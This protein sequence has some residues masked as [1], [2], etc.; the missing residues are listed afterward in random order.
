MNFNFFNLLPAS[1]KTAFFCLFFSQLAVSQTFVGIEKKIE[2]KI[3]DQQFT[4]YEVYEMDLN[5]LV[6]SCKIQETS[7]K[8]LLQ[9]GT[10]HWDLELNSSEIFAKD[11]I[12]QTILPSGERVIST[13]IPNI[14]FKGNEKNSNAKARFV[15]DEGYLSGLIIEE[16]DEYYIEQ[17]NRFVKNSPDNQFVIYA[18][19]AVKR[20]EKDGCIALE[21]ANFQ[22]KNENSIV[23]NSES[24]KSVFACFQLQVAV[25]SDRTMFTKYGSVASVQAH[26]VTVL[27]NVQTNY[28]GQFN[29]DLQFII[30]TNLVFQG[31]DPFTTNTDAGTLLDN[32]TTWGQGGGF[33]SVQFDLGELWTNRD[34]NG[35]TIG[36][37][38]VDAL[39]DP[40]KYH[41]LQDFTTNSDNLRCMTSHEIGHNLN[42]NHD[43]T[44]PPNTI[45]CPF[46]STSNSWSNGSKNTI[47]AYLPPFIAN[48]CLSPCGGSSTNPT[49][50]FSF[51]PNQVCVG[52]NVNFADQ[53]TGGTVT[54]RS[55][56]FQSGSPSSST[57]ANPTANWS[58]PGTYNVTLTVNGGSTNQQQVTVIGPANPSFT[59]IADGLTVTFTNTST[60]ASG[61]VYTWN[62]G[63]GSTSTQTNPTHIYSTSGT[64]LVTLQITTNCGTSSVNNNVTTGPVVNFVANVTNICAGGQVQFTQLC[65]P[66]VQSFNWVFQSGSPNSSNLANPII[67]YNQV[68][69]FYVQLQANSPSGQTVV[70]K[71][72]YI[73]V[74]P[75][76]V[77]NFTFSTTGFN[78]FFTNTSQNGTTYLWNFGDGSTST[79][80]SP[81]HNYTS[82]GT[83]QVTLSVTG[84]CGTV[85]TSKT[86]IL[87]SAPATAFTAST[88]NGCAPLIVQYTN[89]TSGLNNT[90]NWTFPG[91]TPST[92]N[93]AN[94]SIV[95]QNSGVFNA[96]LLATNNVGSNTVTQNNLINVTSVP[97]ATFTSSTNL[98]AVTFTNTSIGATAYQ[99]NFGNGQTSTQTSP[100]NTF[101]SS[102][103][104]TVVL[105]STNACGNATSTQNVVVLLPPIANFIQTPNPSTGCAPMTIQYNSNST[106]TVSGYNWTFPG[107]T[108]ATSTQA[109]PSVQYLAAGMYNVSLTVSNA[110]G[111]NSIAQT[112]VVNVGAAPN[113]IF[114]SANNGLVAT[115]TN[116]SI[117]ATAYEWT[118]GDGISSTLANPQHTYVTD[119]TY[120]VTLTAE[121]T[122]GEK[123][124]TQTV[125]IQTAPTPNFTAL[126]TVGC[127]P[128]SVQ[129]TN[130][131]STNALQ[132][133]WSFPG[134]NPAFSTLPNPTVVYQ[135]AGNYT[136]SLTATNSA[137][138]NLVSKNNFISAGFG[139]AADFTATNAGF[140]AT[141][142]NTSLGATSYF[143]NFGDG[144]TSSNQNPQ[145][146][147]SLDGAYTVTM[148]AYNSCGENTKTSTVTIQ[149][150]P[151]ANFSAA[152]TSGCSPMIVQFSNL[153][154]ANTVQYNWSFPGGTPAT[155]TAS[156][157]SVVYNSVGLYSISL[158]VSN[159]AGEHTMVKTDFISVGT[160]PQ[161][162]FTS[163]MAG[164]LATF[165]NTSTN[166]TSY[167]WTFGDGTNNTLQYPTHTYSND[168]NYTVTLAA[169]NAC[170]TINN[171][172][173]V[174]VVTPPTAGFTTNQ[175]VGCAPFSVQ[176]SNTSSSNTTQYNWTFVGGIPATS[177]EANPLVVYPNVGTYSAILTVSNAAGI[178]T[179]T[180]NNILQVNGLPT[181]D[182]D[183]S[184]NLA[185]L[186]LI[187]N[188]TNA[189][190]YL[191]NFGDGTTSTIQ[192]SGHNYTSDGTY[193]VS[194]TSTN[195]CGSVTS[196]KSVTITTPPLANFSVIQSTGCAPM[197]VQFSDASSANTTGWLWEFTGATIAASTE[198]NPIVT[199]P[200]A[201]TFDVKLTVSNA[202]GN[203]E[204]VKSNF[205][206]INTVPEVLFTTQNDVNGL[207]TFTNASQNANSY[208]WSFGDGTTSTQATPSHLYTNDGIYIISLTAVNACGQSTN[209]Q[210]VTVI[211]PPTAGFTIPSVNSCVPVSMT[212]DNTSSSNASTYSWSFEGGNPAISSEKNP[213]INWTTSGVYTIKL[214]VT[215]AA[216]SSELVQGI[217]VKGPPAASFNTTT[218]GLSVI[219][220]NQSTSAS[221]NNWTFGSGITST[222]E[223]PIFEVAVTGNYIIILTAINECGQNSYTQ[224][225]TVSGTAPLT[226]FTV[227]NIEGCVPYT[228]T[229]EDATIGN[230]TV[231]EWAMPGASPNTSTAQNPTV[232]YNQ[233][234]NYTVSLKTSNIYG[235]NSVIKE[236]FI[237]VGTAPSAIFNIQ[238]TDFQVVFE[239]LSNNGN[240]FSW[241]F[242]DGTTSTEFNPVHVYTQNGAY[243]V[244]LL[245]ANN[246]GAST[247]QKT[248]TILV[249]SLPETFDFQ[250][251]KLFPN[252]NTGQFTVS[253]EGKNANFLDFELLNTIGQSLM[254]RRVDFKNGNLQEEFDLGDLPAAVYV[255]KIAHNGS[256]MY[257]KVSVS[258]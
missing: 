221:S 56:V 223:N 84:P 213:S 229:L 252:P 99:W 98:G 145:H 248:V 247:L 178:N 183:F 85:S 138:S 153:A 193:Q 190:S 29:H 220:N 46:V 34:F 90:Y 111:N 192:N 83:Y 2:N 125:V 119:G 203:S 218:A 80:A 258:Y 100:T 130:T 9:L 133:S 181:A 191:W 166:A 243:T 246:C 18:H 58:S 157:P 77:P 164:L 217:E 116:T 10:H 30:T 232:T 71:N 21:S 42:C 148:T 108:P 47:N 163:T 103:T 162:S 63:D 150:P 123:A 195:P 210:T 37:A 201:G 35:G 167:L 245:S 255:L 66:D 151:T 33:G 107:G 149:T 134:G 121:N 230:P 114:T 70:T 235:T 25:A 87:G 62:F 38:W 31:T 102:G 228:L 129:F 244:T 165:A 76:I 51:S 79:S 81:N 73:V 226:G 189:T 32:F 28:T 147:Y 139:P 146:S 97:T 251:F 118:F 101:T 89:Q 187:N 44:C 15:I 136:V 1:I 169:T 91:G 207:V 175:T 113:A 256:A 86:V 212:F 168:G 27:N 69:V 179:N 188:S 57:S 143:W 214:I 59:S 142:S 53:S 115:F 206:L 12:L 24:A 253:I 144:G 227:N 82:G 104:Y 208:N 194:L 152:Q 78:V 61:A 88:F 40:F 174:V 96:S 124:T 249:V 7:P 117:G 67:N 158:T 209:T 131:S 155:S 186:N 184:T 177:M 160:T 50:A 128:L 154:S 159:G 48:G 224:E 65:S 36:I 23:S 120:T 132:Y 176:Y 240:N 198:K 180:N 11:Y 225:V 105:T 182:F 72:N 140:L 135:T 236:N 17:L 215:N 172:A 55:W 196:I 204:I 250:Q 238:I 22:E 211:T 126:Q 8:F 200:I 94:P 68:G 231:W 52:Q 112:N 75:A 106:G 237:S 205:V 161:T 216:G 234:G 141:F 202:A 233:V 45:M 74:S 173:T 43:A 20:A 92:S 49:A 64:F 16:K 93:E 5:A 156:N 19:S 241:D 110:A 239:N 54:S 41:A 170:G 39:C 6:K 197:V 257:K 13:E 95:Y 122:C 199:Y 137:G 242:G 127:T 171:T 222:E 109:N 254:K 219:C 185:N 14:A 60:N 26:N 3:L 4:Q